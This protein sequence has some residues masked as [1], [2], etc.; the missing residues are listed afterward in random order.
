[1]WIVA[2]IVVVGACWAFWDAGKAYQEAV[3][4]CKQRVRE[5]KEGDGFWPCGENGMRRM[6]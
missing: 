1:M 2:G 3:E 4:E 6:K 5:A